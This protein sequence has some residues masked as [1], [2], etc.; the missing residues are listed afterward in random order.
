VRRSVSA[1]PAAAELQAAFDRLYAEGGLGRVLD[2]GCGRVPALAIPSDVHLVG[3]DVDGR[4]VAENESLDERIVGDVQRYPLP[5]KSMDA[6]LCWNVLEH[7]VEPERAI[8]KIAQALRDGGILAV[9][10][11]NPYSLKGILTKLTPYA[12]HRWAYRRL[13]GSSLTPY[14]TYM[15]RI[16]APKALA[17][18]CSRHGLELEYSEVQA[19][20]IE[21]RLPLLLRIAWKCAEMSLRALSFGR[22][23]P[24]LSE[25]VFLFRKVSG[26]Q[27]STRRA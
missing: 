24:T 9:S 16:I 19:A 27:G 14:P 3:I 12:F 26:F 17:R 23:E 8:E 4:A 13:L 1:D 6:V 21:E 5:S 18:A 10:V 22:Y 25:A 15:R 2:V 11:P 7:L 20:K